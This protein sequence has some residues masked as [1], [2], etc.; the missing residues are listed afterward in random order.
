MSQ[1]I[2]EASVGTVVEEIS[3]KTDANLTSQHLTFPRML[4]YAAPAFALNFLISPAWSILPGIYAKYH[5]LELTAI[6]VV[7]FYSRLFDAIANPIVGILSDYHYERGGQRSTWIVIGGIVLIISA[8]FLFSPPIAV[9]TAY[10]MF[11]SIIF[12]VSYTVVE[13]SHVIVGSEIAVHY[14]DRAKIFSYRQIMISLGEILFFSLP[15]LAIFSS[16]EYTPEML[17]FSAYLGCCMMVVVLILVKH[18]SHIKNA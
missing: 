5:G 16:A 10:F 4:S 9:S 13:I 3:I 18:Y 7:L 17:G 1:K 14:D 12:Y 11:W 15:L 6:A 2:A 8:Y